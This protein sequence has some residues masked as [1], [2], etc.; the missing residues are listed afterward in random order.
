MVMAKFKQEEYYS[1]R[2][3]KEKFLVEVLTKVKDKKEMAALLRDLMTIAEIEEFANRLEI[4]K[5]L[6]KGKSYQKIAGE[7]GVSTATVTRVAHWLFSGCGGYQ[8]VLKKL[9]Q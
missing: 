3:K 6:L 8:K 2:N 1:P 9:L 7:V 5:L 4:A